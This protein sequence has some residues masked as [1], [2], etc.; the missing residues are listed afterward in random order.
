MPAAVG[1]VVGQRQIEPAIAVEVDELVAVRGVTLQDDVGERVGKGGNHAGGAAVHEQ[2]ITI[3]RLAGN[4]VADIK[5]GSSIVV[6][7]TP[8]RRDPVAA[9]V[10]AAGP[11]HLRERLAGVVAI[12]RARPVAGDKQVE[13]AIQVE[14]RDAGAAPPSAAGRG[15][16]ATPMAAAT[17]SNRPPSWR[18][19]PLASPC[20][21]RR[22][23]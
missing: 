5:F 9:E 8:R 6:E 23:D 14:V 2:R 7:I 21:W 17:S 10:N 11:G 16:P 19:K 13:V 1:V 22:T 3:E 12:E 18:Y 4:E 15:V 20:G